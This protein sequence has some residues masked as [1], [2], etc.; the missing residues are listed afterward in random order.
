MTI[1]ECLG[2]IIWIGSVAT[3]GGILGADMGF[4]GT[5]GGV[6]AGGSFAIWLDY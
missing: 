4:W 6:I 5:V 3:F 1:G 2:E